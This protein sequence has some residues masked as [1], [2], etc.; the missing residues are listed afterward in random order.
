LVALRWPI[1]SVAWM[2]SAEMLA[3]MPARTPATA[4][5]IAVAVQGFIRESG[6]QNRQI[7]TNRAC[8]YR[9]DRMR[10]YKDRPRGR[11]RGALSGHPGRADDGGVSLVAAKARM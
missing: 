5:M 6:R 8:R 7:R 10:G 4:R 11:A 3:E 1:E 2:G 9:D